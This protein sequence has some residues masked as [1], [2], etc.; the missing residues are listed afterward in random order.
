MMTGALLMDG[1]GKGGGPDKRMEAFFDI[2]WHDAHDGG[3]GVRHPE[4][5]YV[6]VLDDVPLGQ[7]DLQ[8]CSTQCLRRFFNGIVDAVE[9]RGKKE[10]GSGNA[11]KAKRKAG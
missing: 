5:T 11:G 4:R 3:R 8:F 9:N 2:G 7:A 10:G 6:S 1:K